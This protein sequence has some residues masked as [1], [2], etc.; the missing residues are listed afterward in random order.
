M[1]YGAFDPETCVAE[2]R[3]PA[4]SFVV[5]GKFTIV[6]NLQLL[7]IG[8]LQNLFVKKDSFFDP[9]FRH[10]LDK[11]RFLKRLVDIMS[12]PILPSDEDYHYLPT[13]AIAE[14][15]SE[16]MEPQIDGLVFPSSQLG[17]SGENVVL[18]RGASSVELD[19]SE[20]M[21]MEVIFE[22]PWYGKEDGDF[23]ILLHYCLDVQSN[24]FNW[25]RYT[26]SGEKPSPVVS[27]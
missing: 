20:K 16:K 2:V 15:L 5:L 12:R 3:P 13:Q 1:F 24:N 19:G 17:G 4:G 18:F 23:N 8:A 22:R 9:E 27:S 26:G 11:A 6:R 7:D 21:R 14:Y 10:L 25:L